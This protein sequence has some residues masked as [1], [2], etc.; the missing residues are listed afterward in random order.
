MVHAQDNKQRTPLMT[1]IMSENQ[2]SALVI[3]KCKFVVD[4]DLLTLTDDNNMNALQYCILFNDQSTAAGIRTIELA[5]FEQP[6]SNPA[7]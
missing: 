1:A 3:L 2:G 5:F 6:T 4:T 7:D